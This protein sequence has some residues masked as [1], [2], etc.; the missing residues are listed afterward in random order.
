VIIR[1]DT[2]HV[3]DH[4]EL[5][6]HGGLPIKHGFGPG[7]GMCTVENVAGVITRARRAWEGER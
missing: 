5:C 1:R 3:I 2:T 4:I 6:A 7:G